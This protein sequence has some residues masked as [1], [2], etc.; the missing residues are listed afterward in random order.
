MESVLCC[1][2]HTGDLRIHSLL[3]E[4]RHEYLF[5]DGRSGSPT[6][7]CRVIIRKTAFTSGSG[8]GIPVIPG[9]TTG[10]SRWRRY[11]PPG[12]TGPG[13]AT[14]YTTRVPGIRSGI[15]SASGRTTLSR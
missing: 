3:A 15:I 10:T 5:A 13:I 1:L 12:L 14:R 7:L 4:C 11:C 8:A 2:I 6:R 9:V